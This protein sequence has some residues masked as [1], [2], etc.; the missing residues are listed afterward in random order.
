MRTFGAAWRFITIFPFFTRAGDDEV[1]LLRRC[2][3]TFPF[4]GLILGLVTGAAVWLL[5]AVL[6]VPVVAALAVT[7]LAMYSAGFHLDGLSDCGD[8]LL[9]PGRDKEK[10][11]AIMKDSRI[12]A[13]GAMALVLLLLTKYACLAATPDRYGLAAMAF[14]MPLA[15]RAGMLWVM[16][17]LP[18]ARSEGLGNIIVV[19]MG[20]IALGIVALAAAAFLT[21]GPVRAVA[22]MAVWLAVSLAWTL[23]LKRRLGGA[24]GDC[25]GAACE[26]AETAA[27]IGLLVT[28]ST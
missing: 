27:G 20:H 4:I 8:A 2:G 1:D 10:C 3:W 7:V 16:G 28:V 6:P 15:G 5:A 22:V 14:L 9:S 13:H 25:Y 26:L 12:G 21:V 19:T 11:L 17:L 23:Y 18:Y 24:T